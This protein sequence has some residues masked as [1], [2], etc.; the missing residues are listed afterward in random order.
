MHAPC[1]IFLAIARPHF[2]KHFVGIAFRPGLRMRMMP[3]AALCQCALHTREGHVELRCQKLV[4]ARERLHRLNRA[5]KVSIIYTWLVTTLHNV[6]SFFALSLV[7]FYCTL[8][9]LLSL[10]RCRQ[11]SAAFCTRL[12]KT[13][14]L[15]RTS[16]IVLPVLDCQE[17]PFFSVLHR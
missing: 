13:L 5:S 4:R 10:S 8:T 1:S 16:C 17:A 7:L 15:R 11:P 9:S 14:T 3:C 12:R 2:Y 6:L